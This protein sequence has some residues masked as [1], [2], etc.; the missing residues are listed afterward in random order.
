MKELKEKID[1]IFYILKKID[2]NITNSTSTSVDKM[3]DIVNTAAIKASN[4]V[5][6]T[7]AI[8]AFN[9]VIDTAAITASNLVIDTAVITASN[10]IDI[11]F[12]N[13]MYVKCL[14]HEI[15][16]PITNIILGINSIEINIKE[17]EKNNELLN[18]IDGL[19][20]SLNFIEDILTKFCVIKNGIMVLNIFQ[21]FSI[22]KLMN[23]IEN[24]LQYNINEKNIQLKCN[25]NEN[26]CDMVYGDVVNI[27][28][29]IVNLIKNSIK[30]SNNNQ[31]NDIIIININNLNQ[32]NK[33]Q[34]III[35]VLD[36][37]NH[38]PKHIKDKL[39]Q[40]FNS[41][42]G[43]GLGLYICKNILKLHNGSIEHE[44][45]NNIHGNQFNI[46]IDFEI[47]HHLNLEENI[48]IE[49]E[50]SKINENI[51]YNIIL[52]DDSELTIKL[53]CK[54]LKKNNKINN[55]ITAKD[56]LDAIQKICN[57]MN[58]F[59]IVFI[60]NQMPNLN[61]IQTVQL[62]RGINFD[63]II[64]GITGSS[65]TELSNFN[66][67]GIDYLFSKPLDKNKIDLIISF[68]NK[69]NIVR[70]TGKKIQLNNFKLEWV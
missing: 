32:D 33:Y 59:D 58:E 55:I 53:M 4:L 5:I 70:Q 46:F 37:N 43:S 16:T 30:Y 20:K 31:N 41:T 68:L 63:K 11:N 21:P 42:S 6:D 38:I 19:Y 14:I 39:F 34:S 15:R 3:I 8:T 24:L 35:S 54:I 64:I 10:I 27:K 56:G 44:Y 13:N 29:C 2:I 36:N 12:D 62:L 67:C 48:I 22:K 60:D 57:N 52:V 66:L 69:D 47:Q 23:D 28:H 50:K 7:A 9:L 45:I 65:L 40:P 26:V 25:I 61:G 51:K 17:Y 18:T 49:C 1:K